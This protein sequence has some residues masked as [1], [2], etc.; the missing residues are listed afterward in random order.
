MY[1][2]CARILG[3]VSR[4]VW[5]ASLS[6]QVWSGQTEIINQIWLNLNFNVASLE[7]YDHTWQP[8]GGVGGDGV[9]GG[10]DGGGGDGGNDR[11]LC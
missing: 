3:A 7:H 2:I 9:G 4:G 10:G 5:T 11:E 8:G 1:F 6:P